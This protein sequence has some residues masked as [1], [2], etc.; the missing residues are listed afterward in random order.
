MENKHKVVKLNCGDVVIGIV[1][2]NPSGQRIMRKPWEYAK[3]QGGYTVIPY[4]GLLYGQNL[5][6]QDLVIKPDHIV[7]EFELDRVPDLKKAYFE[8][9]MAASGIQI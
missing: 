1:T 2:N 6:V 7:Y 3:V 9:S 5:E 4:Q 8:R